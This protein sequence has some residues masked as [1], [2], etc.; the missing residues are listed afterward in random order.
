MFFY[1]I[2]ESILNWT[3]YSLKIKFK[4]NYIGKLI[5]IIAE[6]TESSPF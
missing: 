6:N 5:S 3:K 1:K 2:L 4:Y